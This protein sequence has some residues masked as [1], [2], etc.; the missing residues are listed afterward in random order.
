[1]QLNELMHEMRNALAVAKA[2]LEAFVDGKL[3]PTPQR[4]DGVLQALA[5]LE[6]M[7]DDLRVIGPTVEATDQRRQINICQLLEREYGAIEANAHAK[8]I[9]VDITRCAMASDQCR[10]FFGDPVRISQIVKNV[11]L[12]AVRYTPL[13]G[14]LSIDCSRRANQLEIRIDDSGPGVDPA[15]TGKVFDSGF[16][17]SAAASSDQPGS[18]FGLALVKRLVEEQ[19][20]RVTIGEAAGLGGARFTVRLP[21]RLELP[22][23]ASCAACHEALLDSAD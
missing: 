13:H 7:L 1:M 2:N 11:L 18:G 19:G 8:D 23:G 5:Q 6:S 10:H 16:R 17:G 4:L 15:E 9:T 22:D 14:S 20:G 12:N 3:A 21:G